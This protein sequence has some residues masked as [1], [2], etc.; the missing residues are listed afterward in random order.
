MM[1][2]FSLPMFFPPCFSSLLQVMV[3]TVNLSVLFHQLDN[4][5]KSPSCVSIHLLHWNSLVILLF[6]LS[7]FF[8]PFF[9]FP[10]LSGA[11]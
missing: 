5:M 11:A 8:P 3:T 9:S 7:I 4:A 2:P 6:Y 1:L 10:Y